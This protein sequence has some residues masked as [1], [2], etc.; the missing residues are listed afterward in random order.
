MNNKIK[1]YQDIMELIRKYGE[2]QFNQEL[3]KSMD[4]LVKLEKR[5]AE[6]AF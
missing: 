6:L 3:G 1:K 4:V 5:I 2:L